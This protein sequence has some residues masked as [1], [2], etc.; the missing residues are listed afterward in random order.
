M[1]KGNA[2]GADLSSLAAEPAALVERATT[3]TTM[4]TELGADGADALKAAALS[5]A[6]DAAIDEAR[7]RL[8]RNRDGEPNADS[9]DATA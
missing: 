9:G 2:L 3:V 7:E 1:E 5:K 8:R 4:V 6:S